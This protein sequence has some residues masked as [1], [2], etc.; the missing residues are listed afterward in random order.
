MQKFT[1]KHVDA[2]ST[3]PF[4]GNP[5]GV[6]TEADGLTREAMQWIAGEMNLSESAF[7]TL[8][9]SEDTIFRIRFFTP[10]EEVNLSGHVTIATCFALIEE[11]RIPL[12]NGITKVA[13][14]TNV[15]SIPVDI[16]FNTDTASDDEDG[17]GGISLSIPDF[18]D[19]ILEKIM[20]HQSIKRYRPASFP[21]A[22]IAKIL[23]IDE[24]E[25]TRTGLPLEIISTGLEQFMIPVLHKETI[26]E[27]NP[28]LIKLGL[29]NS[30]F[31]IH[32][33]HIFTLDTFNQD[34][35]SYSRHFAPSVGMWEDPATGTA[36]AGLGTYLYRHG[37][38]TS[39]SLTMEQGKETDSLAK[40][41]VELGDNVEETGAVQ[42]GGLAVT[43]IKRTIEID[44]G[45]FIIS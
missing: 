11:G 30:K 42:V 27:M 5:A 2:F 19:G 1:V 10:S 28:D 31:G 15:G 16:Y 41:L 6:I 18:T 4:C 20:M 45:E 25:I 23:G 21:I 37:V 14:G 34:C 12:R 38:I 26:L 9:E 17:V 40:I 35:T 36:A 22:E 32:T 3:K 13:F 33:N 29:M 39:G 44:S 7:V 24:G 8:P 43:S